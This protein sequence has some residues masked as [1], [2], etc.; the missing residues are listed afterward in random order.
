MGPLAQK[1]IAQYHL[2]PLDGEGGY[3]RRTFTS[4]ASLQTS[5]ISPLF[6]EQMLPLV[7][8]IYYLITHESFS[9]LHRLHSS[10]VWTWLEGDPAV[11][12]TLDSP[13][14]LT[15]TVIGP[16]GLMRAVKFV[17]GGDWQATR[18]IDSGTRG[19]ALFSISVVPSFDRA[20][21]TLADEAFLSSLD[22]EL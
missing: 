2:T 13:R 17:E 22:E 12:I 16:E 15:E 19:Y 9:S 18:L 1:I 20:D 10:E 21:F 7:S 4:R 5:A 14:K 8:H 3:V 11:M 6:N